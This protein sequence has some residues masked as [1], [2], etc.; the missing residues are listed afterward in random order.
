MATQP[1]CVLTQGL[2]D[3]YVGYSPFALFCVWKTRQLIMLHYLSRNYFLLFF[4]L[5]TALFWGLAVI[6]AFRSYS[7]VPFWDMWN[8]YLEFYIKASSNDYGAWWR[9]HNEHR[10]ILSRLFFWIDLSLFDGSIWF[11]LLVNYLLIALSCFV[12]FIA[13]KEML[14][15]Y[16]AIPGLFVVTWLIS[17]SQHENLTWGFQS[18][19]ILA[20]LL[21]LAAFFLLHRSSKSSALS[22]GYFI[23]ACLFGLLSIGSMAN[24]LI[25]LP[26]MI[27]YAIIAKFSWKRVFVVAALACIGFLA[28]FYNFTSPTHHGSLS[29]SLRE[30]P[31]GLI[32]YMMTY[33]GG[34]F[35]YVVGGRFG[36]IIFAQVAG[37]LFI[38]LSAYTSWTILRTRKKSTLELSLLLFIIYI[39]GTALATAGGRLIF[40][41]EQALSP[42]YMTPS[43]MAW[44]A[45]FT[46]IIPKFVTSSERLKWQ[47]WT[48]LS[49]LTIVMLPMQIKSLYP[50]SSGIFERNIA[51]LAVAMDVNDQ[52]QISRVFPSAEYVLAIGKTAFERGLSFFSRTEFKNI[53]KLGSQSDGFSGLSSICEGD[54]EYI[55]PVEGEN[56]YLRVVGWIFDQARKKSPS[57]IWLINQQGIVVGYGLVGQPR[58]DIANTVDRRAD[59]SGFK[60]YLLSDAQGSAVTVLAPVNNCGFSF[61]LPEILLDFSTDRKIKPVTVDETNILPSNQW[62]GADSYKSKIND[63][64]VIGSFINSDADKGSVSLRVNRGDRILYRSGPTFG[65]QYLDFN[66]KNPSV[67]LPTSV[68]WVVL[69]FSSKGLPDSFVVTFRDDG[70]G[71]GEWSAIAVLAKEVNK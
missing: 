42:R 19:F 48:P 53:N 38:L 64:V 20:Q 4:L 43:L 11:L 12:F 25:A 63:H 9:S 58:P 55:G 16:Y 46:I 52:S 37:G 36:G 6:G 23:G 5:A 35:Y 10:I 32:L 45:L 26:L 59:F 71:W 15:K 14:P 60:G 51:G 33:I 24:G 47:L 40:G 7:P 68:D 34:P 22:N 39:G 44:A 62:S 13:L 28:Y 27:L 70:D 54:I 49:L 41:I 61:T 67:L 1:S 31:L 3:N 8:G 2:L 30:N 57:T 17:W 69:E 29:G 66:F 65:K 21:P 18:Q 50:D 56:N